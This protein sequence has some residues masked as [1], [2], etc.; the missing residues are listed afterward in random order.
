[1]AV[2]PKMGK[3]DK[4][5]KKTEKSGKHDKHE[6]HSKHSKKSRDEKEEKH[7][8]KR[9]SSDEKSGNSADVNVEKVISSED[10]FLKNEEFRVWLRLDKGK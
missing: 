2:V 5:E 6:K 3:E 8:K 1:M 7:E 4:K 10:F 9:H